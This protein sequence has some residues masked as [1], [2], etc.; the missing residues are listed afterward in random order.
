MSTPDDRPTAVQPT[1]VQPEVSTA[2]ATGRA[3]RWRHRLPARIG[4]ARTSTVVIGCLFVLL[5]ALHVAVKPDPVQ[6]TTVKDANTGAVITVPASL[7]PS[8]PS[9]PAPTSST[10]APATS[11]APSIRTTATTSG[12]PRSTTTAS[13]STT[14]APTTT[15]PRTSSTAPADGETTPASSSDKPSPSTAGETSAAPSS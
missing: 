14:D 11:S 5:Y 6:Y 8:A 12:T 10:E 1:A 3:G 15:A 9:T 7:V 4:R 2:P 13:R